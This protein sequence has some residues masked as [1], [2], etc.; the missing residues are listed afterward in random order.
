MGGVVTKIL[1]VK[2]VSE[3]L[4][5]KQSTGLCLGRTAPHPFLQNQR[6]PPVRRRRGPRMGS[7]PLAIIA[8]SKREPEKEAKDKWGSSSETAFIGSVTC[9]KDRGFGNRAL[10]KNKYRI[11]MFY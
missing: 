1:T 5:A 9:T 8:V 2:Q 4:Q 7:L 3:L 10:H 6:S 11:I